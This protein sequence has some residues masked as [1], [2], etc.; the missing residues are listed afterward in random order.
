MNTDVIG[1]NIKQLRHIRGLTQQELADKIGISWE[2]VS[3][4]ERGISS[5]MNRISTL[6]KAL[7]VS[8]QQLLQENNISSTN[9]LQDGPGSN[10]IPYIHKPS[11]NLKDVAG[12]QRMFYNAPDWIVVKDRETVIIDHNIFK[13]H[14][15]IIKE[16]DPIYV[17]PNT[18]PNSQSIIVRVEPNTK[19]LIVEPY[20]YSKPQTDILGVVL[21]QENRIG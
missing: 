4:Y 14:T 2:M 20:R 19:L 11:Q 15:A 18:E 9:S 10:R 13:S 8:M 5:P 3:R 6:A 7:D 21:A 12:D 17:S 1:Q 16:T